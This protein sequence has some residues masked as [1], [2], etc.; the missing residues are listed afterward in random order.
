MTMLA[1]FQSV[2]DEYGDYSWRRLDTIPAV[3]SYGKD[4]FAAGAVSS[5]GTRSYVNGCRVLGLALL[6]PGDIVVVRKPSGAVMSFCF[7]G[8][9]AVREAGQGRICGLTHLPIEG[10]AVRCPCGCI[11]DEAVA[12]QLGACPQ[13]GADLALAEPSAPEGEELL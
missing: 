11:V 2:Q 7:R 8:R 3:V 9:C 1:A 6:K 10:Q 13:C 5:R 12:V 4:D